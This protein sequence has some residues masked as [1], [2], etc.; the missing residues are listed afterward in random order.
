V[1]VAQVV[2]RTGDIRWAY[3]L[4]ALVSLPV[5]G[6]L[7]RL[8]SP[9][10]RTAS[11]AEPGRQVDSGLVALTTLF[12]LLY[13]GAEQGLGGWISTYSLRL[14]LASETTAAYLASAFWGALTIG[15]LLAIPVAARVRPSRIVA[16]GLAG[17]LASALLLVVSG[18]S[19]AMLWAGTVGLGMS[20]API[21]PT[22]LALVER[23]MA[24]TGKATGWFFAGLGI[25][26]MTIP[27]LIGQF[28]ERIGPSS[29]TW[30]ILASVVLA[31]VVFAWLM[32]YSGRMARRRARIVTSS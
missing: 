10:Q 15:R 4:V 9:A 31:A 25:G 21:V 6:W 1:I 26:G 27:L 14:Q 8:P 20:L 12:F 22:T 30:A 18:R 3:W 28:F 29:M 7:L 16:A 23:R 32:S 11:Q 2:A 5:M 13:I 17:A 19:A 24:V